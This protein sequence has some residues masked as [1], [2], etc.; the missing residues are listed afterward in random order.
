[1]LTSI[2]SINLVLI[3]QDKTVVISYYQCRYIIGRRKEG[4]KSFSAVESQKI[5]RYIVRLYRQRKKEHGICC[6]PTAGIQL[7]RHPICIDLLIFD[8]IDWWRN[9][10]FFHPGLYRSFCIFLHLWVRFV[11]LC[12]CVRHIRRAHNFVSVSFYFRAIIAGTLSSLDRSMT[13][14]KRSFQF[15]GRILYFNVSPHTPLYTKELKS[16]FCW[17][18]FFLISPSDGEPFGWAQPEYSRAVRIQICRIY[19]TEA[20]LSFKTS[21]TSFWLP[22]HQRIKV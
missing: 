6:A 4:E 11:L 7:Y 12:Q 1:M 19:R 17:K 15:F 22:D 13:E 5:K 3:C 10:V 20:F 2:L 18:P 21:E 9:S 16:L 8:S 14:K